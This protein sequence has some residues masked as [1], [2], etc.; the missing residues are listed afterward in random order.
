MVIRFCVEYDGRGFH[1]FQRQSG[2]VSVQQVLEGALSQYFGRGITIVGSGRTDA[3][4]HARGQVCSF[5]IDSFEGLGEKDAYKIAAA[6]NSFLPDS[7]AVR[8]FC[9]AGDGFHAQ[10]YAK[11]KTYVYR[12]YVSPYRSPLRDWNHLQLFKMPDVARMRKAAKMLE[13]EHDFACFGRAEGN[14]R[15]KSTVRTVHE[16][17]VRAGEV[18]PD[19]EIH[20]VVRG[21][22]FLHN[23]VRIMCGVLLDVGYG[24]IEPEAVAAMLDGKRCDVATKTLTARGLTLECVE[25]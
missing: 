17:N 3:G 24:K 13:G 15:L 16:F 25:Y 22:G 4:V 23:M 8:D 20:F 19:D 9:V 2:K 6:V 11:S 18:L 5:R 21:S 14:S 10:I 1:G 7:V 12:C